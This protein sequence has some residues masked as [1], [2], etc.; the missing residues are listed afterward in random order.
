LPAD[1]FGLR[2]VIS[3]YY[4]GG[5]VISSLEARRIAEGWGCWRGLAAFYLIIAEVLGVA[6]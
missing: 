2:R 4:C 3:R 1:D 6:F 5:K